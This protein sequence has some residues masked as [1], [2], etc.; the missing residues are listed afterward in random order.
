MSIISCLHDVSVLRFKNGSLLHQV[1]A[2]VK[3]NNAKKIWNVSHISIISCLHDVPV[4]RFKKCS[5]LHQVVSGV[6]INDV[7]KFF[8]E[9]YPHKYNFRSL[10]CSSAEIL[11]VL[12]LPPGGVRCQNK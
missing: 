3:I 4:L 10:W 5:L 7:K 8:L 6:K 1:V 11:E 2:G 9:I 12:L